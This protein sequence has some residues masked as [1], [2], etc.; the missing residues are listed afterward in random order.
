MQSAHS[1]E[2]ELSP[3]A[4]HCPD[5][6][7][8]WSFGPMAGRSPVMLRLFSQMRHIARHLRIATLEGESGTGKMLAARSLHEC[9]I[10]PQSPFVPCSAVQLCEAQPGLAL[11]PPRSTPKPDFS[12]LPALKQSC[13]GTLVLT[14]IDELTSAHQG[15]LLE[16]LQWIDHQHILHAPESI[17]RRILC[18]SSQPL[19]K[20]ASTAAMRADLA[21]RLTAIRFTLPPL[22]ERSEDIPL[23]AD[24]FAQRFSGAH[25]KPIRGLNPQALPRLM[26]YTWP[27]NV[28]ELESVIYAAALSCQGQWIRPIDLPA[29]TAAPAP[30]ATPRSFTPDDD[31]NLDRAI[32]RHIQQVLA[33]VEGNKLRAAKLLGISRSTLYRLLDTAATSRTC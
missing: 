4:A 11:V 10:N 31:P 2:E 19:R 24:L 5:C 17:P 32:L 26:Q 15:R 14:R 23:L 3:I 27:G 16:L 6:P 9:G 21:N 1:I 28:R 18:L 13:G 29:F 33:R 12:A 20:L 30:P 8:E 25:G 7:P 22:R